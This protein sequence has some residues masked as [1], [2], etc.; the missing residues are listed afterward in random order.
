MKASPALCAGC[1][2]V[3]S[4]YFLFPAFRS[5]SIGT[6]MLFIPVLAS[7]VALCFFRVLASG[8]ADLFAGRIRPRTLLALPRLLA[9]FAVGLVLGIG[10][11]ARVSPNPVFGIPAD[12]VTGISGILRD[13]PRMISGGRAMATVSL[14]TLFGTGGVRATRTGARGEMTV[15]F[16]EENT[17]RLREFGRGTR[18]F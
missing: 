13:D 11:G 4:Y 9:A 18:V 17:E 12:T 3:L 8:P 2:A 5:G 1:G 7:V 15:F 14:E 6:G 10:A 16:R